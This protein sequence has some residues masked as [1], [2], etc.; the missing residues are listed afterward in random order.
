MME[1]HVSILKHQCSQKNVNFL[2]F[3]AS[4]RRT[5]MLFGKEFNEFPRALP[6]PSE[7]WRYRMMDMIIKKIVKFLP[8]F[9]RARERPRKFV[10][11]LPNFRRA[12]ERP[13]KFVKFLPNFGRARERP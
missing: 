13:R 8:N 2:N 7:I 5:T 10:K 12:R 9:R 3:S 11:F 4:P 1:K 6:R